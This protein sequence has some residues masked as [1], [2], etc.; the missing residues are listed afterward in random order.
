M[1]TGRP[2]KINNAKNRVHSIVLTTNAERIFRHLNK[3]QGTKWLNKLVSKTICDNY[4]TDEDFVLKQ[5]LLDFQDIRDEWNTKIQ[6]VADKIR[7]NRKSRLIK[8]KEIRIQQ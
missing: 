3:I 7:E 5:E 1:K 8:Q 4:C 2:T 6:G